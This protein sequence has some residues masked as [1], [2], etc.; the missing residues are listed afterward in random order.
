MRLPRRLLRPRTR[1]A[2]VGTP[3]CGNTWLRL[4]I[5]D[6]CGIAEFAEHRVDDFAWHDLPDEFVLQVHAHPRPE[7]RAR[8]QRLGIRP[9]AL[10]RHPLDV[11][12]SILQYASPTTDSER[13]LDGEGGDETSLHDASPTGESFA[14]YALGQRAD[15]LLSLTPEWY[16]DPGCAR[17]RYEDLAADP[18]TTLSALLGRRAASRRISEAVEH[19]TVGA[20]RAAVGAQHVWQGRPG[21]WRG[22]LPR[23]VASP[24]AAHHAG[25]LRALG[26]ACEL[27]GT[28]SRPEAEELW[29]RLNES[30]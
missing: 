3:R 25:V 22:L 23:E 18:Q 30:R 26:Y 14:R 21:L 12:I 1:L 5:A 10:A 16:A 6:C 15:A 13:W 24:I 9:I 4:L 11:L 29:R 20:V 27:D 17:V 19:H 7:L 2:I 8:L 28:P